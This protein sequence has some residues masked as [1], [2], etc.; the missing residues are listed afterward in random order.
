MKQFPEA[1][2]ICKKREENF[3]ANFLLKLPAC[4]NSFRHLLLLSQYLTLIT[5]LNNS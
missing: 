1:P 4:G 3:A 2:G 5:G